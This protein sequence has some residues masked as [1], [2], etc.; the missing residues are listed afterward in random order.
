MRWR[1]E[2][3]AVIQSATPDL[4]A[5]RAVNLAL[6]SAA[7]LSRRKLSLAVLARAIAGSGLTKGRSHRHCK[8][9]LFRFLSNDR[10]DPLSVQTSPMSSVSAAARPKGLTPIMI[11]WSDLGRGFNGLF[12][13]VCFRKRGLPI[14]S[15]V[16]RP[17]ELNPSQNR[18][19]EMFV[20]RLVAR[21]PDE[22]RPLI[23]ADRGFGRASFIRFIQNLPSVRGYPV[24]FVARVKGN[25]WV[26]TDEF[27]GILRNHP[28]WKRRYVLLSRARRRRRGAVVVNLVLC[29]GSGHKEPWHLAT[30]LS[31][32]PLAVKMH[33]KRMQPERYFRDGK[34]RFDL[35]STTVSSSRRLQRLLAG[36][37]LARAILILVGL[38]LV[39][40]KAPAS[41]RRQAR[42][43]GRLGVL[44]LGLEYCLATPVLPLRYLGLPN[45]QSGC[46]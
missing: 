14:L 25:V 4:R 5:T 39:G 40:M 8:K 21:L 43:W 29:W 31:D 42:S 33:R 44:H 26:E 2:I 46:A 20:R 16:S 3:L 38:I 28:L 41:F 15:W 24:D 17:E 13:A 23:L 27:E 34:R 12:A 36:V 22:I 18:V 9:R 45:P 10:F 32:A 6:L 11:D 7:I 19:E 35:D 30:S 1:N 37:L